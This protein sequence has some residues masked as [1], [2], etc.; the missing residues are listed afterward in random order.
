MAQNRILVEEAALDAAISDYQGKKAIM[1]NSYQKLN[2]TVE[3]LS[4]TYKGEASEAFRARFQEM[5]QNLSK[6]STAMGEEI[7]KIKYAVENYSSFEEAVKALI[8]AIVEGVSY[9]A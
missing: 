2:Q 7:G 1:E 8:E 9:L 6:A 3:E 5:Y 4:T